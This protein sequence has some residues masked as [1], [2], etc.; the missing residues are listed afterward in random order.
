MV[1]LVI[2]CF[3]IPRAF[4]FSEIKSRKEIAAIFCETLKYVSKSQQNVFGVLC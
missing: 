3:G 1:A 4:I 2:H